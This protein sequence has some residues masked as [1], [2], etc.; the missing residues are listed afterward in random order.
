MVTLR[1]YE[2]LQVE[3]ERNLQE[4]DGCDSI[5]FSEPISHIFI[6]ANIRKRTGAKGTTYQVRYPSKA[7][8]S[9]FAYEKFATLKEA[10][11]FTEN[12]GSHKATIRTNTKTVP[13]SIGLWLDICEKVG[14][15][16][17]EQVEPQTLVEYQRRAG[18]MMEYAWSKGL[19]ELEPPDIVHFRDWLLR[20]KSRDL[21]RRTL[22]SFHSVLIEMKRQGYISDDPAAG[23][24]IKSGGRYEDQNSEID[25]PSDAE[26]RD[27]YG[28]ADSLGSKNEQMRKCWA[29]YRPM[30]YLAGFSGMRPSEYRGLA[31]SHVFDDSVTVRQRADKTGIIG[32]VK[33]RAGKRTIY[34][35]ALVTEMIFEWQ[36]ECPASDINLV[37]PTETGRAQLLSNFYR[38][39]WLPLMREAG[40]IEAE[41]SKR[42]GK[43][44]ELPRYSPYALRHYY[45]SKLIAIGTDAKTIQR[46]MGHSNIEIT[47]NVYGHLMKDREGAYKSTAEALARE[48]LG[49]S[50]AKSVPTA[51]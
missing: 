51:R 19:Q 46:T 45:A 16:G 42:T 17:R 18:V 25:I 26:V 31:W 39:A 38:R 7:E 27:I 20:H 33:S 28:A 10:R 40:L 48:I 35:P 34:L 14:R 3:A 6:M 9:G 41:K 21:A 43:K 11:A 8:K 37:F 2:N 29:R 15:D 4:P 12:L 24:T 49:T 22:S 30:I 36:D 23:I 13:Q 47:F 44:I 5:F 1:P 32:P 50:C